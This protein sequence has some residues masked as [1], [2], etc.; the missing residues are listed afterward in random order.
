MPK[1]Y[2]DDKK[3]KNQE[4]I[5]V[6]HAGEF[7]ARR[8]YEG[9]LEYTT[10]PKDKK[11]ISHMLEQELAHLDY[12]EEQMKTQKVRPTILMPFWNIGGYLLGAVAAKI[13][14]KS[15]MLVTDAVEEV[16]ESHYQEQIDY[17]TVR[18]SK[19]PMLPSI[20]QFQQEEIQHKHTAIAHDS[21]K[22]PLAN[23]MF[24]VVGKICKLAINLS[25]KI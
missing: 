22:A 4:I 20:K 14:N 8:I 3:Q 24:G 2:F 6:N 25:K 7:G 23:F 19:N 1:P 17:L 16:I 10:N 15:A 18:D 12:F 9:Q 13:N 11:I 21:K 5:R